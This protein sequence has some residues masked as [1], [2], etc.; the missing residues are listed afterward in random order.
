MEGWKK[1]GWLACAR[2]P[3]RAHRALGG[4]SRFGR[5]EQGRR[6]GRR[7]KVTLDVAEGHQG[8]RGRLLPPL[9]LPPIRYISRRLHSEMPE[10]TLPSLPPVISRY[11]LFRL[12]REDDRGHGCCSGARL[13]PPVVPIRLFGLEGKNSAD[14][15]VQ[16]IRSRF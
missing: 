8:G 13:R 5:P 9:L 4:A 16:R 11:S 7:R 10:S 1:G 6:R 2:V 15:L 3:D 12:P 14:D